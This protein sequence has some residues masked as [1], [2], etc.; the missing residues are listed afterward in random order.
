M[1]LVPVEL[2]RVMLVE[3][4]DQQVL[5]LGEKEGGRSFPIVV[6]IFEAVAIH[7]KLRG[8]TMPRP[9]THDLLLSVIEG[10]GGKLTQVVVNDL[11]EGTFYGQLHIVVGEDLYSID[12]RPSDGIALAV[13]AECPIMVDE[14]VFDKL[15]AG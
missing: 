7:R 15:A 3:T 12:T 10:M 8:E 13:R 1:A 9:M 14:R 5:V 2:T 6:G 4:S 11:V